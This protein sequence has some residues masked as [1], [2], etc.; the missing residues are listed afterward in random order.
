M[1]RLCK[2]VC[3]GGGGG[4]GGLNIL[5]SY[6]VLEKYPLDLGKYVTGSDILGLVEKKSAI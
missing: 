1:T 5:H 4:G 2:C 3:G 6:E